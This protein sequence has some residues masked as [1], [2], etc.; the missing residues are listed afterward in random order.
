[1]T[2]RAATMLCVLFAAFL[3]LIPVAARADRST[4]VIGLSGI[5]ETMDPHLLW[6]TTWMPPYYALYDALTVIGDNNDAQPGLAASWK[7]VDPTTW[8]FKLRDKV[9]FHNG[10]PFTSEAVKFTL[11]RVIDPATKAAVKNRVP[12]IKAVEAMDPLTVR[13]VTATPDPNVPKSVSVVFILPPKY[14]K[15]KGPGGFAEAPVGTGMFRLAEF[16]RQ[17]HVKL[18]A[19]DNGWRPAPKLK[20]VVFRHLPEN[21]TRIAALR[22]GDVDFINPVPPDEAAALEKDGFKMAASYTGWSYVIQIKGQ[23]QASSP[24]ANPLVRQALNYAVDKEALIKHVL[25]GYGR[26]LDGQNVG[27]DGF[28]HNPALKAFPHDPAK[29]RDLL[30]QAGHPNGFETTWFGTVG[31][32]PNDKQLI[33]AII[34]DLSKVGVRVKLQTVDQGSFAKHLYGGTLSDLVLLRWTYFPSL[35]F[36]FVL[37]LMRCQNSLK[38]FCD[39]RVDRMLEESRG[40]PTPAARQA[41]LRKVSEHLAEAP[42]AIFL[43]QP[44][45]VSAMAGTVKGFR[46]RSEAILWLDTVEKEK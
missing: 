40:A 28:G 44:G 27:R 23:T 41:T 29:A 13:I 19:V 12:T 25:H 10:E 15:E 5:P 34:G 4:L 18:E 36:D 39:E 30:K 26:A 2:R 14:F 45:N 46:T 7:R 6:G 22:S 32:Y 20:Q 31:F 1:V 17:S 35:D 11:D 43:F 38:V 8:E 37:N 24:L 16:R 21:A 33:E 3:A 9:K 42:N